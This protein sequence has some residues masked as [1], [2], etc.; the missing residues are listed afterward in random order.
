M[1]ID[2]I[3]SMQL[4]TL[5]TY[6]KPGTTVVVTGN[7]ESL[8]DLV[9][10]V[11]HFI[12][13]GN[14]KTSASLTIHAGGFYCK[15]GT[16]S[17]SSSEIHADEGQYSKLNGRITRRISNLGINIIETSEGFKIAAPSK[18]RRFCQLM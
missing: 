10:R 16:I 2:Y 6:N 4:K 12:L 13:L 18:K 14:I 11:K 15:L 1:S 7:I 3:D 17:C 5:F 8:A 9:F